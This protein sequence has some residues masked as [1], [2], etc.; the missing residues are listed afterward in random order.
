MRGLRLHEPRRAPGLR[1]DQTEAEHELWRRLRN[2][3]LG[4]FKFVRQEPIGPYFADVVC[5]E[6]KLVVEIDGAT[7][8]T[9]DERRRDEQREQALRDRGYRVSRFHNDEVYRDID[10][11]LDTILAALERRRTL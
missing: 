5:R 2:R 6:E 11:V 4:G 3:T 7:H 8:S 9:N 10:G 1:R